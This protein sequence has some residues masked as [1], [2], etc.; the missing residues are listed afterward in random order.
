MA[1]QPV[2]FSFEPVLAGAHVQVTV[3]CGPDGSRAL[4]GTLTMRS[5]EWS[6]LRWLLASTPPLQ[7]NESYIPSFAKGQSTIMFHTP[8][9]CMAPIVVQPERMGEIYAERITD[10]LRAAEGAD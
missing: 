4:C 1:N 10:L 2:S 3:R 6:L 8:I 5:G 7:S 9:D